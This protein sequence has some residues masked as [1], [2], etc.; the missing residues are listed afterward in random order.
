MAGES[1]EV[2]S[3]L[4]SPDY[5]AAKISEQWQTWKQDKAPFEARIAENIKYVYATSTKETENAQNDWDHSTHV[6]KLAHIYDTLKANYLDGL[7]PHK[8]WLNIQSEGGLHRDQKLK[9]LAYLKTKHRLRNLRGKVETLLDDWILA[10]NCFGAVSYVR[11]THIN[12]LTQDTEIGYQ[13]PEVTR[14]SPYDIV[15]N[16]TASTFE[17]TPKIIRTVMTLGEVA[18]ELEEN[19]G[20]R[21][22]A[23]V[24]QEVLDRRGRLMQYTIDDINK[25]RQM[26]LDGFGTIGEYYKGD[27]VEFLHFY[28]DIYDVSEG[29]LY[30]NHVITVVDRDRL[31]RNSPL[32]TWSGRPHIYHAAWRTRTDNLWGQ[33]PLDNLAGMQYRINHL[34]NARADAFDEMLFGDL[35][36]RGDVEVRQGDN[37]QTVYIAPE[38]GDVR[39]LAPDPTVL[40]ADFQITA[41]EQKMELFAGAPREAMGF[42]TAGEKTKFE[43]SVLTNAAARLFQHKMTRFE[44]DI[45]EKIVNAEIEVSKLN[46]NGK[47]VASLDD[48]DANISAIVEI[49]RDDLQFNGKIIPVGA[50]NF[51][52]QAQ[53]ASDLLQ[54][55]QS[56]LQDQ[57]VRVH[58]PSKKLA[59]AWERVLGAEEFE[60]YEEFGQIPEQME[61]QRLASAAQTQLDVEKEAALSELEG[62]GNQ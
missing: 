44:I 42:R 53:Q 19:P 45:L 55:Q 4:G 17:K 7:M 46:L 24:L 36:F 41:Y 32:N 43:V 39:R 61:A 21:Y 18:R 38:N 56:A 33:G 37:G 16:L 54:F 58:F 22:D 6:P 1:I 47:D 26:Q 12:P 30:K 5:L 35:V 11:E 31:V 57:G 23:A 10:G 40:N 2:E 8:D 27:L 59:K 14:I 52:R 13:G 51:A 15:F 62:G 28:G 34:E 29:R 60:L 3:I 20:V 25:S 50:R 48:P 49:T 9:I